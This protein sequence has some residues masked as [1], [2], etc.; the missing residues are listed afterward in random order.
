[1]LKMYFST[2]STTEKN[3]RAGSSTKKILT[4]SK[5]RDKNTIA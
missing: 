2:G 3:L 1:M 5:V 4:G